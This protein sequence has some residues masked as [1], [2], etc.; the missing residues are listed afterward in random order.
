MT[1]QVHRAERA[2]V[3]ADALAEVLAEPLPDPFAEE[4]VA[5]PARGIERWLAQRLSLRLGR[6]ASRADGICA[7]VRFPQPAAL[8]A[9][10]AGWG[11]GLGRRED[12]WAPD[13]LVWPLL[14]VLDQ[15]AGEAW[16][17]PLTR[18][19]GTAEQGDEL[20]RS[21]RYAVAR[22][23]AGL[24]DAYAT[25]RVGM[26]ADWLLRRDTD[27]LGA[28]LPPDLAWQ[29][30]L[31]RRLRDQVDGPDPVAGAAA[32]LD[33]LRSDP[34]ATDLPTRLSLFGPTRLARQQLDVLA[35]VATH[36]DVHL[37][38]P[39]PSPSLWETLQDGDFRRN[40]RR[41]DS[42]VTAVRNPL[43]ASL[44]RDSREVQLT[45]A[46]VEHADV[47]HPGAV[48][49]D[50]LLGRLQ[51]R[52]RDDEVAAPGVLA[53][54]DRSV[55]VH[56][57]AGAARQVEVLREILVGLL[58]DDPTL[59]PRDILVM[60]PD[61]DAFAPL[62][63]ADFGLADVVPADRSH[64][65]HQLRVR[66][67]DRALVQSNPL[68][69]TVT[70]LLDLAAGRA[71]ASEILD[72]AGW[73]PVRRRFRFDD[74]DLDRLARWVSASGV[75]WGLDAAH[76]RPF[77]LQNFPQN[78]WQAG[79]D[80]IL[81]GV[82]MADE[83]GNQLG[84][85]LPLDDVGS[86]DV[87]RAGRLAELVDRVATA[88]DTLTGRHSVRQWVD[89]IAGAVD[90]ITQ[91][92]PD[93]AWQRAEL[94]RTL[95]DILSG[96]GDLADSLTMSLG[97]LRALLDQRWQGRPTRANFRTGTL[98]VCTMVPMRSVPHRVVCL[99]GLDDGVFPRNRNPDGDDILARDPVTGERDARGEDRQLLL[100]AI[101]AATEHLVVT[102]A[103]TDERTGAPR[104]PAVPLGELL[105]ALDSCG[106]TESGRPARSQILTR[107]PLQPFDPAAVVPGRL[108]VPGPFSHDPTVLAAA[109]AAAGERHPEPPFLTAA[110]PAQ[111]GDDV[112]L[113]DLVALLQHPARGFLRQR[114][115][116]ATRFEEDEPADRLTVELDALQR[117][118]MGDRILRDRLHGL[119]LV[120]CRAAE[121]R[122]GMLPPGPLGGRALEAVLGQVE[123]LVAAATPLTGP[124]ARSVDVTLD[125][126]GGR[127]LRGTVPDVHDTCTVSVGFSKLGPKAQLGAWVSALA[128]SAG[129]PETAWTAVAIGRGETGQAALARF[130]PVPPKLAGE[131]LRQL[132]EI[133]D[134]GRREP[135][136]LPLKAS[137]EYARAVRSGR[138]EDEAAMRAARKWASGDFPGE[139]AE[140]P[141]VLVWGPGAPF[142]VLTGPAPGP[143]ED[144]SGAASRWA[145]L[146]LRVWTPLLNAM[147]VETR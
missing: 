10:A 142:T 76:R 107:H 60:C 56:A 62:I 96:A 86:G 57:C 58:A 98:T 120:D 85:A 44:G 109:R 9:Q 46:E 22:R 108:G 7:G 93:D 73:P 81:L 99:V 68:L 30:E 83:Q 75:R 95:A 71:G 114:L 119:D 133:Y 18:H 147:R 126:G 69:G 6:S 42:S 84:L 4:V 15:C 144:W 39:H 45:L 135:L 79:L 124:P 122:R 54:D 67:A 134:K 40:T 63:G 113:A 131:V 11:G 33:R 66:L 130:G 143:G 14:H 132:V 74:D 138:G 50:T 52:L 37:W 64:P 12:P 100:D 16:C 82:S 65:A 61:I 140:S 2:D 115:D 128:L 29:P 19:L 80:R 41:R 59:Q 72:L 26:L 102:Y 35:A 121:W 110:L 28:E 111:N 5:V 129:R 31:W 24:F 1:L 20:G 8:V 91:V 101:L 127:R 47:H 105:D 49:A 89:A 117:W 139:D 112:D 141:H 21:R 106:R 87:D 25:Q 53:A 38:L 23:L 123:P 116:V 13:R 17:A 137:A 55:Q 103:G 125:L 51:T 94:H 104:P 27:G 88:V 34:T 146:A 70:R 36:R 32:V 92:S 3:L 43:L 118:Q 145:E 90:S 77:Q 48:F 78:T 97:D 136:P